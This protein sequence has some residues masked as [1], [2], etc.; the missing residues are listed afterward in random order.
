MA[1]KPIATR[2]NQLLKEPCIIIV[3]YLERAA[4]LLLVL[5]REHLS[6]IHLIALVV[7]HLSPNGI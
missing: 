5:F 4:H 2:P 1:H 3:Q 7:V 6:P